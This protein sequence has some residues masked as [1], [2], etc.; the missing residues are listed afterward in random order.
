LKTGKDSMLRELGLDSSITRLDSLDRV[1]GFKM[2]GGTSYH[3][4]LEGRHLVLFSH[5]EGV[6]EEPDS[7]YLLGHA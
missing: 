1:V 7:S 2:G 6:I 4:W 3:F 5:L